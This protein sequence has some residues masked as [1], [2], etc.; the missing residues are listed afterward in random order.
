M[1]KG[2]KMSG[3]KSVCVYCGSSNR[4]DPKYLTLGENM[5]RAIARRGVR[6]VYGGGDVGLMG[7][8][9]RTALA[10]GGKVLGVM[11]KFLT[12]IEKPNPAI[13]TRLVDT[14]HE[15]KWMLF[16]EADAFIVLP[17]GIGTLEE[18]VET[19]SWYRLSLHRKP[20]V[21]VDTAFWA[22]FFKLID[23]TVDVGF[24]PIDFRNAYMA[25]DTPEE[26]LDALEAALARAAA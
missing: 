15:R 4:V 14:M 13:E 25:V 11:P 5:G 2:K 21:F 17:G 20:S 1:G 24:T 19:L 7:A 22:P 10:E 8:S 18:I 9:S 3:L 23:Q 12:T 26:A 6:L 16:D